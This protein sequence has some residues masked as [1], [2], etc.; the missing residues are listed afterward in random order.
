[1]KKEFRRHYFLFLF[2]AFFL[3]PFCAVAQEPQ[4]F[5]VL[6]TCGDVSGPSGK[7]ITAF[8]EKLK[9]RSSGRLDI[10]PIPMGT[11]VGFG[12]LFEGVKTGAAQM[13]WVPPNILPQK[14]PIS[15]IEAGIPGTLKNFQEQQ[16]LL[17]E[18][19]LA[20][21]IRA[22]YAVNNIHWIGVWPSSAES[23]VSTVPIHSIHDLKG[24]KFRSSGSIG[25]AIIKFGGSAIMKPLNEI[26]SMLSTGVVDA[27]TFDSPAANYGKGFHEVT[28]YWQASPGMQNLYNISLQANMDFWLSLPKDLQIMIEEESQL[29]AE[30]F[31]RLKKQEDETALKK[32]QKDYGVTVIR[33]SDADM[34]EWAA[35]VKDI[36]N[37]NYRLDNAS[38]EAMDLVWDYM[39]E[40]GR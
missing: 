36:F 13:A 14:N 3:A 1:M 2:G 32:V 15:M 23:F 34:R 30:Q 38:A 17:Y 9:E 6:M 27:A 12:D 16:E 4:K 21:L 37:E 25:K 8:T 35:V 28:K 5:K 40:L 18:R 11:I 20:D 10:R 24:V 39:N 22:E 31:W 33:W 29:H 7:A 19:G 26:Y